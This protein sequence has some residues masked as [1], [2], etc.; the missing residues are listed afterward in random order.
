MYGPPP[1]PPPGPS[2]APRRSTPP[3]VTILASIAVGG[4]AASAVLVALV[5]TV[6]S[7]RDRGAHPEFPDPPVVEKP[8][9]P[10]PPAPEPAPPPLHA[11]RIGDSIKAPAKIRDV[12]PV[13]PQ[14]A[15]SARVQ[16]TVVIEATIDR[17][18]KVS[19]ARVLR[20][21]PLLDQAALDA[22]RQWEYEPS[23]VHGEAVPVIM[24][25]TV[26]FTLR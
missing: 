21:I 6:V 26:N 15:I 8:R 19:E 12:R 14:I 13:Y 18:G 11:V 25:V 9:A 2:A 3:W 16:G 20:S 5:A 22:V 4:L 24:T 17:E 7:M 10:E 23:R 1:P